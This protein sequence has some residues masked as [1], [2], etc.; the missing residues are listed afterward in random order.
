MRIMR[1]TWAEV[2][3]AKAT[4]NPDAPGADLHCGEF[5]V[6]R[7]GRSLPPSA[8]VIDDLDSGER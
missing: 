4:Q 5:V 1:R 3:I 7:A 6:L 2:V 8:P